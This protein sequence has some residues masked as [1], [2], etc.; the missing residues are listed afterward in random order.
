M[1]VTLQELSDSTWYNQ[2]MLIEV[3]NQRITMANAFDIRKPEFK[4][5]KNR[6]V[7][8]IGADGGILVVRLI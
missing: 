7:R 1:R 8:S 6:W 2:K 3:D 4:N 5:L